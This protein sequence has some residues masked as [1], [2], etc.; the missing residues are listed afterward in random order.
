M[1]YS[2]Y[3]LE[4]ASRDHLLGLFPPKYPDVVAHHAT[5]G[6]GDHQMPFTDEIK[7]IGYVDDGKG[8]ECLLV[9]VLGREDRPTDGKPFHI[10]WSID[11][12]KGYKPVHSNRVI[13]EVEAQPV[14]DVPVRVRPQVVR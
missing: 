12:S 7:V 8:L 9:K 6:M 10:T 5:Y 11:R 4:S 2:A 1:A 13:Q 14:P 3:V